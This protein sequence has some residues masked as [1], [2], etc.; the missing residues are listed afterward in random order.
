MTPIILLSPALTPVLLHMHEPLT[1]Y[2]VLL[3]FQCFSTPI[4]NVP[5]TSIIYYL[6]LQLHCF[7]TCMGQ[8][9]CA[10]ISYSLL[11]QLRCFCTSISNCYVLV[12]HVTV[13]TFAQCGLG[14]L[15]KYTEWSVLGSVLSTKSEEDL[16]SF[17]W[18]VVNLQR[19]KSLLWR[20]TVRGFWP[21][22]EGIWGLLASTRVQ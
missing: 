5:C 13:G 3:Q 1:Y 11:L 8:V 18:W 22:G 16:D 12:C 14:S 7:S 17:L 4:N 2:S 20:I 15:S 10:S 9:L 6:L 19:N 21:K